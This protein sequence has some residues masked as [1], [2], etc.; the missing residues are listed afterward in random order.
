MGTM[1]GVHD[2]V[3]LALF[4]ILVIKKNEKVM[5]KKKRKNED[6]LSVSGSAI[7]MK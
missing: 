6:T 7:Y 4:K 2:D 1:N 3:I 5:K